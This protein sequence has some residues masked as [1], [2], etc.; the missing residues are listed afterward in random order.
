MN[1]MIP[2][3]PHLSF[4]AYLEGDKVREHLDEYVN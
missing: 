2:G 3:P 1:I 4:V